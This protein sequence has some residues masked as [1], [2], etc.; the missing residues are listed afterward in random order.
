MNKTT[1]RS[2]IL[3]QRK[4]LNKKQIILLSKKIVN[5][6]IHSELYKQAKHI[7]IYLPFNGEVDLTD[8]L[9]IKNK[10]H[11]LP[12]IQAEQMQF[13]L[14][15]PELLIKKHQ[16]GIM[17]PAYINSLEKTPLDLCLMPLVS[18]DMMGNRLGMGGGFY[19]RYFESHNNNEISNN[20]TQLAGVGY[21]FQQHQQLPTQSWD[22]KINHLYTESGYLKI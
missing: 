5:N 17:Q 4:Y 3:K 10:Y 9:K 15:T 1:I 13:Q 18:F 19:D 12:S 22:V 14:Y 16:F 21:R 2:N 20:Q 8:L 11:Y 6:I 7:A